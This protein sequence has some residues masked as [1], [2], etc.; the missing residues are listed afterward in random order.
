MLEYVMQRKLEFNALENYALI[1]T[2]N[3]RAVVTGTHCLT[4]W[5]LKQKQCVIFSEQACCTNLLLCGFSH[6]LLQQPFEVGATIVS[7]LYEIKIG[8][9][10]L[11]VL[12]KITH[13]GRSITR[14]SSQV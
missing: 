14:I 5:G 2:E 4:I 3:Y 7:I 9:K 11:K 10:K 8:F 6:R 1:W 12:P 13:L